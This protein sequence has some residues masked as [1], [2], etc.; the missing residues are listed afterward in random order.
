VRAL[1]RVFLVGWRQ[2]GMYLFSAFAHGVYARG[3]AGDVFGE[4]CRALRV[5]LH[6][7]GHGCR[8]AMRVFACSPCGSLG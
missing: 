3:Y 8:W 7:F 5:Y 1:G 6:V 4:L 2:G